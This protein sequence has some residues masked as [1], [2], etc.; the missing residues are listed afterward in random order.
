[1]LPITTNEKIIVTKIFNEWNIQLSLELQEIIINIKKDNLIDIYQTSLTFEK[2]KEFKLFFSKSTING[3]F[4]L[5]VLL[6][7]QKTI[8]IIENENN[9]N[10]I[11]FTKDNNSNANIILDKKRILNKNHNL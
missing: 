6:I 8:Q 9:L 5:I 2:L 10:L 7:S 3:I 1:M 4:E 11:L